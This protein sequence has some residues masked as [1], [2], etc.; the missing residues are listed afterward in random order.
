[1][2]MLFVAICG[3]LVYGLAT[4]QT[5]SD[6]TEMEET[7][8]MVREFMTTERELTIGEE[9]RLSDDESDGFWPVYEEYRAEI[10]QIQDRN[11]QLIADYAANFDNLTETAATDLIDDYFAI[12]NAMLDTRQKYV[13]VFL[14]VLSPQKLAR[15]YQIENKIDAVAQLP[16]VRDIPLID[17]PGTVRRE[18]R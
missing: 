16:L 13:A 8:A 10:D 17:V 3:S 12:Q 5:N 6:A 14:E 11:A 7:F 1:M 18:P 4:A 9:L 15:F 2:R